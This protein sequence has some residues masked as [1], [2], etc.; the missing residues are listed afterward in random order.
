VIAKKEKKYYAT[1]AEVLSD[2]FGKRIQKDQLTVITFCLFGMCNWIYA[3]Y[4]PKGPV[5][6][7]MLSKIIYGI[8]SIGVRQFDEFKE[9]VT[10]TS[11]QKE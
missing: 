9:R 1:L 6:P 3:W 8:F 7:E 5:T 10:M 11:D 4:D 2:Y